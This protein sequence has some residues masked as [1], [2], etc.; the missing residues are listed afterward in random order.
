[1]IVDPRD[2]PDVVAVI[3]TLGVHED[4]LRRA[5]ESVAAQQTELRL[6]I[7]VVVNSPDAM[8]VATVPNAKVLYPGFNLGFAGGLALGRDAAP[9][10]RWIWLVQDDMVAE[11]DC[12]A[13][14]VDVLQR[15]PSQAIAS[16]IVVDLDGLVPAH[17]CGGVLEQTANGDID[18]WEPQRPTPIDELPDLSHIDYV[19]SRGMLVDAAAWDAVGGLYAGFYPV[20]WADVDFCDRVRRSGRRFGLASRARVRHEGGTSTSGPYARFLYARHRELFRARAA[21]TPTSP[22]GDVA[23]WLVLDVAV[24]STRLASDL[25]STY[26]D[27]LHERIALD[28]A[29]HDARHEARE[30]LHVARESITDLERRLSLAESERDD[31]RRA[32]DDAAHR[33]DAARAATDEARREVA[34]VLASTSWRV[35]RPVRWIGRTLRRW[36]RQRHPST[37]DGQWHG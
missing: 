34:E 16:P 20:I 6:A 32:V 4:R 5:A 26:T 17:S 29:L 28:T 22:V 30:A 19:P 37:P 33:L 12:L 3:P 2:A 8:A 9:R 25:A 1:M 7:V 35:T 23:P 31:A 18:H 13:E 14:L 21:G 36:G 10:A 24:A 27:E 11:N 15:D